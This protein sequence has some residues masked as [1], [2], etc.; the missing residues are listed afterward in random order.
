[1]AKIVRMLSGDPGKTPG[2]MNPFVSAKF[3]RF[4]KGDAFK[5]TPPVPGVGCSGGVSDD[6]D[7]ESLAATRTL[8]V[9]RVSGDEGVCYIDIWHDIGGSYG[10]HVG[11]AQINVNVMSE[12]PTHGAGQEETLQVSDSPTHCPRVHRPARPRPGAPTGARQTRHAR[13]ASSSLL[14]AEWIRSTCKSSVERLACWIVCCIHKT[15]PA[16]A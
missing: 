12:I 15:L 13:A 1:M 5:R 14:L 10:Q 16:P 11:S 7:F 3:G 6:V 2:V 4:T 8:L 9:P